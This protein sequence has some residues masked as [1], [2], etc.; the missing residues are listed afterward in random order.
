MTRHTNLRNLR[1][2]IASLLAYMLLTSQLA[3]MAMAL[4]RSAVRNASGGKS[5]VEHNNSGEAPTQGRVDSSFAP[6]PVP[7]RV[8][9]AGM[10]PI[11]TATKVDSFSDPD[12][13]GKVSPGQTITYSVTIQN[14]GPDPAFN[15]TLNDTVDSNTTIVPGSATSTPI[16]TDE[17]YD[18][19]GNVRIQPNAAGGL[20]ANDVDPNTGDN[21][22][23]TASGP[24]TGPTNGQAT[25]NA[26]GSFSYNP[27]PG[28][29]GT[30]SFTYTVT[31]SGGTDTATVTLNVAGMM[32]F[33]NAAAA[34]GGDGRLTDPFNCLVGA[35]CFDPVAGDDPGDNIFLYTGTYTDTGA[36]TLLN[37]QKVI[38][39]GTSSGTTLQA[40][41][42]VTLPPHSDTLPALNG[43]P[44][45]VT[46]NSAA[47]GIVV[48]TGNN[49][50]LRGFTLGNNGSGAKIFSTAFGTLTVSEVALSGTGT[51][52]N[53]DSGTLA[54]TF[55]SIAS[56]TAA[57]QGILLDQVAGT[58][59]STGGTT[60]TDPAT[61]GI[62]V[63]AS[64]ADINFGN[65][66]VS[67]A[68]DAI[69]LQNN[70]A[71]TRTFGTITTTGGTGVGFL[72]STGGGTVNVTGATSITNPGG[73]GI[74]ID[75]SNANLSFAATTVNKNSTG[76]TGVDLT[77][78]ATRTIGFTSLTVTTTNA[79]SLNTN[80]SGT[81]NS[82]GGSLTQSGAGGGAASLTNTTLGLTF[83]SVSSNGGG[84]GIIISGGSGTFTSGTTNLQNNAGI[85]LLMSSSAVT[86]NFGNT[87]VNSSAGDAVDLSS[88]TGAITFADL[89]LTP[90]ANLR[91]LDASNNTG[92][93]TSTSGDIAT[94]GAPAINISGPAG[95]TPLSMTLTNVDSTNSTTFGVDLNLV[96][97]NLTVNDPGVATNISNPTGIGI[98]VQN[99]GAGTVNFGNSSITDSGGTGVFL[100]AN[101]GAVTFADVDIAPD[102]GQRPFHATSNTGAITS[103][104]GTFTTPNNVVALE[105]VGVSAA[106]KTPLNMQLNTVPANGG[107][108][109]I[110]ITNTSTTGSPG[111]FRVLGNGGVCTV[112]TP[113]CTGGTIQNMT[114]AGI[115]LTE[116]AGINLTLVRVNAGTDD[117]IRG[118][119]VTNF[120]LS[121]SLITNNGNA[122]TERGIE[123]TNLLGTAS[124]TGST[125]S[126]S[127]EDNLFVMNGTGTLSLTT[128]TTTFSNTSAS[129]GNDGIH[130]LGAA[131]SGSNNANMS[132]S[133]TNCI[134]TNNRGD[135][136]QAT[137]DAAS[138]ATQ[139]IVFQ[140]NDLNNTVGTNLGA[141]LTLNPGGTANVTFNISN[142]GTAV[143]PFSG[144]FVSAITINSSN[145]STMSGT[146]NNNV[147]GAAAVVDSGSFSGDGITVFANNTSDIT[148]AIT[149]NQINQYS[150]LAGINIHV[151]DGASGTINATIT[152]NTISNPGTFASHGIF[153]QAGSVTGDN[154]SL[155]L[156]IG[157]AGALANTI[158]GSGANGG[159][160]FRVRQRILTTVRLPG[161]G[162][163]NND[164][165]AVVVFIQ[166]RNNGAETGSATNNVAGGGGGF[167]GGAACTQPSAPEILGISSRPFSSSQMRSLEATAEIIPATGTVSAEHNSLVLGN[168]DKR[169]SSAALRYAVASVSA[170]LGQ[171]QISGSQDKQTKGGGNKPAAP[172]TTGS[173]PQQTGGST[174]PTSQTSLPSGVV[175]DPGLRY[176]P[177][178]KPA[179]PPD[180]TPPVI[181]GD[182]LTWN[183]GTLPAGGS[184]T[185]TF[186]VVV[187][188]PFMG[189]MP[190]VSNQGTVT[191]DGGISVL[192][193]DPDTAAPNDPTVTGVTLPPDLFVRDA[194]VAE[195]A[196][197]STSM[198]FTLALSTPAPTGG[199]TVNLSTA[200]GTATGGTCLAGDDYTTVTGGTATFAAGESLKT[201]PVTVCSD[202]NV[203]GDET[204]FL[205]V[206]SA[207]GAVIA[208]GQGLGTI[209][210]NVPGTII[211]SE[212]RTSGPGG[213]GDDFVEIYNN[214][215]TP[216]T[217]P[218]GG[219]GLFKR[220]AD[221]NALPVLVGT[222]PAMTV[223]PQR[224]HYLFVGSAY[225]LANYGGTGA[226]AGNQTL[227]A[228]IESDFNVGL[229]STVD[230]LAISTANRLDAVGF[231]VSTGGVCDLLLEGTTLLPASGSTS[232]HSFVREFTLVGNDV[233]TPT[234]GNDNAA[235][236]TVVS[237]TP[238]IA[239]GSNA[240]PKLGAPGPENL[241]GPPLKKFSQVGSQLIDPMVPTAAQPNRFRDT[242]PDP[243]NNSTLGTIAFRRT[244]INNTGAP[245]T[246]LRFRVYDITTFPSP[247]GTADLRAR[248]SSNAT[249]T[250]TG[251]GSVTA[252]A[253]T[254][255]TP[256]VQPSSGGLNS[257]LVAGTVTM[258]TPLAPGAS[259]HLNFL[260]GVQQGGSFRAFVIVEALP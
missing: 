28:F 129:V 196:S 115:S 14:T 69:S 111:G 100:N 158:G 211:I 17:T 83:T 260:F 74:D 231:G 137:T 138:A 148:V 87:T 162:G 70:S 30:D 221:C 37:N 110:I 223:I 102:A 68:T 125:I 126:G 7:L 133:V 23:L 165:A 72:H 75:G 212:L 113:T 73:N 112:A 238:T 175:V 120:D 140:N 230:P 172:S 114:G 186:Q 235:D 117:G 99:T 19:L 153:A 91:G 77:N 85:G 250:V 219:Y 213:A 183:V 143:D 60:I 253:T 40:A 173:A 136:F 177:K 194:S 215:D 1:T 241:T 163:A 193:D 234:D 6:V 134:F 67:D 29:T 255:E 41:A 202:A 127:A 66:T 192:T 16:A 190:Q 222:I 21:S 42:G 26:D 20:L 64:I 45:S 93:I 197:G 8:T 55:T 131:V 128:S 139:N 15:V 141:G 179:T 205:N 257:G 5:V 189:A 22:G 106:S 184:V 198:I 13:D 90:D 96:S 236:F 36:L 226:A 245:I 65:T 157:G 167:V 89:D 204:F 185:I 94:T 200:N 81:V 54:A 142:N 88:N 208:D 239:V 12:M 170:P 32:W 188:D 43:N 229:F 169:N 151:R 116:T 248:T 227:A 108:N 48:T 121:N 35:G 233:P 161:Y 80:N 122:V 214:T 62:L 4:N 244:F 123:M 103:T 79:F 217:V 63:T 118:L 98:R 243:P 150:N 58:L 210:A 104:S 237:T 178:P 201:F 160:D 187:D 44:G 149:N 232:E 49:N 105:I 11:I 57:G 155:C 27:N 166:G 180:V 216:H 50:T 47:S 209:T 59:T 53:L 199:I 9:A 174:K 46:V 86:A 18:V 119:N 146:I 258:G 249:V 191:A 34:P 10:V 109:G 101:A 240:T 132:I 171:T 144:A 61:Q 92:T 218:G 33:V 52:L 145:D 147:I 95:R 225:S 252:L 31:S 164:D 154:G 39:Q 195:P 228:D 3:P 84:N 130:F 251:V 135:H 71:G 38:G 51:A 25:V 247:V 24:T 254:L 76:G 182:T 206:D 159:T 82:G 156:D 256:P 224:G 181:V 246:R 259:I 242:T 124:I 56:T 107:V 152:G 220:G 78:N 207:P 97:G 203:E 168:R 176:I 2:S